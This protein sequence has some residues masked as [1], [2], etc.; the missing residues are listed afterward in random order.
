MLCW[1]PWVYWP[2]LVGRSDRCGPYSAIYRSAHMDG[3]DRA[4]VN[5]LPVFEDEDNVIAD[6][7]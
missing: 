3:D 4:A 7:H 1:L 6:F 5:A 2:E